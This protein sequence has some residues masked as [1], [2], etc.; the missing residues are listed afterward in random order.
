MRVRLTVVAAVATLLSSIGL[1]PL[2]M[3]GDWIWAGLGAII[4]VASA[5][6]L[7]RRLRMSAP[8]CLAVSLAGLHL[9]LT[10]VYTAH[11]A[12]FWIIPTPR[13]LAKLVSLLGDGWSVANHYAAPVP[14]QRGVSLLAA[15]GIGLVAV[16][17]DFLAVR[18]RRAAPAGLPLL[19]MYSVPAAVHEESIG[20]LA[21]LFGAAGFMTLLLADAQEQVSGWGRHVYSARWTDEN[22]SEPGDRPVRAVTAER[23]DSS[24]LSASGRRIGLAALTIAV[25]VP[26][27][28]PGIHPKGLFGLGGNG[29]GS[30]S[31]GANL[32]R[33]PNG[34]VSMHKEL[35]QPGNAVVLTYRTDDP[36]PDPEYLRMYAL[37]RFDGE[38]WKESSFATTAKDQIK[39][40][41]LPPA[42][43]L[44][45]STPTQLV[46]TKI[47]ID[48]HTKG[49]T[50]LPLP[51]A[52]YRV[53]LNGDWR[54]Q[55]PSLMVFSLKD[56]ADAKTFTV[57]SVR[58]LPTVDQLQRVSG[59]GYE[60]QIVDATVVPP[61]VPSSILL[62]AKKVVAAAHA[63]GPY[64]QAVALEHWFSTTGGFSY[65]LNSPEPTGVSDLENFIFRQKVGYCEQFASAMALMARELGIPARVSVGYTQG[66]REGDHWVVRTSDAHA[67]PELYFNGAGWI[68]FEP[69]PV[70]T[71]TIAG[72]GS[73]T[74]PSYA[75]TPSERGQ[76][77]GDTPSGQ[78]G[79]AQ[80]NANAAP[81]L[82]G[83]HLN[84]PDG[85]AA[86]LAA[87]KKS[88]GPPLGWIVAG[89]LVVL[90]LAAPMA[91]R[92]VARRRRWAQGTATAPG[93]DPAP[94]PPGPGRAPKSSAALDPAETAHAA[95]AE[96]RAD[97]IDH[98]L[99]WRTSDTPRATARRLAELLELGTGAVAALDRI[100]NAEERARYA[101]T[102]APPHTLRADVRLMREAF[103]AGVSR[104]ARLRAKLAPPTAMDSMR[105]AGAQ[106][107]EALDHQAARLRA[108]LRL[109]HR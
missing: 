54:V 90:L 67:W 11:Q 15:L 25:I 104:T 48:K 50:F 99:P 3:G 6:L 18:L 10:A 40:K 65:S 94:R 12:L 102:P 55:V 45:P 26:I 78:A 96:L 43:G 80:G 103:A 108:L 85:P 62:Q 72:Q 82:R 61:S 64:Q 98:G 8:L 20:W 27:F 59:G 66:T 1:H 4:A 17:V 109:P 60:Q 93:K 16:T 95:W 19:A 13:S 89:V 41:A 30:G 38:V 32:I 81:G 63:R 44:T 29:P 86:P 92:L 34:L 5:G 39:N 2:F 23:P 33:T 100:S 87:P 97:A 53:Q 75:E 105:T 57:T 70:G 69:T 36:D 24:A 31:G 42:Q 7:A 47:S 91:V 28:V 58:A 106:A 73:A 9:Y 84:E 22:L 68:R 107:L 76:Q 52:P 74:V 56:S 83:H 35:L 51:Y 77:S 79:G 101:T 71:Q 14:L 21:F 37:D 49:V 88:P 46:N